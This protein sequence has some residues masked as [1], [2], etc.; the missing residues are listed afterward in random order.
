MTLSY[1][2]FYDFVQTLALAFSFYTLWEKVL[3]KSLKCH[4]RYNGHSHPSLT[5]TAVSY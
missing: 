4:V 3:G 2:P 5:V 1:N